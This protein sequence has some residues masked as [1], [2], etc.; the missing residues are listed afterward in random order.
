MTR[1]PRALIGLLLGLVPSSPTDA[2]TAFPSEPPEMAVIVGSARLPID[3]PDTR[4]VELAAKAP[5]NHA[6]WYEAWD[7][8]P[9]VGL[10]KKPNV[11]RLSPKADEEGVPILGGL[12]RAFLPETVEVT[13]PDGSRKFVAGT[14]YAYNADWGQIANLKGGLGEEFSAEVKVRARYGL[15][16]LDLVQAD[17]A[18]RASVKRGSSRPV[19]PALPEPDPGR[20]PLAGVYVGPR[21]SAITA[22]DIFPIQPKPPVAPI[23]A[24]AIAVTLGRLDR[25]EE[26][27]IAFLGDSITVG[28]EAGKWWEKAHA[29]TE[30]DLSW[31]GRLV[32]GLRQRFP[33]ATVTPIEGFSGGKTSAFGLE[34]LDRVVLPAV[35]SLV[36]IA[37]GTNDAGGKVG[38]EPTNPP[39][40]F[41][42][43]LLAMVKKARAAGAE[44]LLV[45]P[46]QVNPWLKNQQSERWSG[47]Q[48][49]ML[50]LAASETVGLADVH[51]EW[52]NL[53]SRGIPPFTQ[54]HNS[55]NHPGA[56]GHG[57][58]AEVLLRFFTPG[59]GAPAPVPSPAAVAPPT[60][61]AEPGVIRF[62]IPQPEK[63]PGN[64]ELPSQALPPLADITARP[65]DDRPV[66]GLYCWADEYLKHHDF[67]RD[68][69][70]KNFRLSGPVHDAV[71]KQYAEDGAEVMFTVSARRPM[72]SKDRTQ[73]DWRNR[74]DYP[75]DEA[76]IE[77]YLADVDRVL[78][79][80]AAH[81][82]FWKENP[83]L[84]RSPL[85]FLEIYNEPNFWY[86]DTAREDRINHF[87][88]K[89]PAARDAQNASRQKL[90]GKLLAAAYPRVKA[91]APEMSVVGF[92]A[93]GSS[94]ADVPFIKG[95]HAQLPAAAKCYD[96][97]STHPYVRPC[98][99]EG[100]DVRPYGR[101]SILGGWTQIRE[102]MRSTGSGD[103]PI[104]W[105]E[106]NWTIYPD[107]GGGY[108][109]AQLDPRAR[110]RDT[111]PELQAAY[112]VRG[113]ALAL[114]LGVPRLFYM[115]LVD[116]DNVNS[117]M[118][119]P[120]GTPRLSGKAV[121]AMIS[122]MPHPRIV[123]AVSDGDGGFHAWWFETDAKQTAGKRVLM[124]WN[125]AGP[126]TVSLPWPSS[127]V[128]IADMLG[129]EKA[130]PVS[131]GTL[132][133]RVGP[134]PL[135]LSAE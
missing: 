73:G 80:Y 113:Y 76:F 34:Q 2:A 124:A 33:K 100:L 6:R 107:S 118:L 55:V 20:T 75:T 69:G 103:K 92:G 117:G 23:N 44:V 46:M 102:I 37:F 43:E 15:Q 83:S 17:A 74:R 132:R 5:R 64:W 32:H 39:E 123:G 1:P 56:F 42:Q 24:G 127:R 84:P 30:K 61:E 36:I 128:R 4:S 109:L 119:S 134:C 86:L 10:D 48:K 96:I 65:P 115:S 88:P 11:I 78:D 112:L 70:W 114:R 79:R 27:R 21:A 45:T 130:F 129:E 126:K 87:P 16:R 72:P 93:G 35:P 62:G 66:Y 19:C 8:W 63:V 59:A 29:Y 22:A 60:P 108:S 110:D 125:V 90:Y 53:A 38:G 51:A 135:Y 31:R 47:Y 121:K 82:S 58:Y 52:L 18:G 101:F 85:R 67:I 105:T 99:P 25:G 98:P 14:H 26:A 95:V 71:M 116:T 120:A 54:L 3:P 7:P 122:L 77:D 91:R 133:L 111:T 131:G 28:A 9:D 104:W 97:L 40:Q 50:A 57:V 81:G 106:L 13:S 89:D 12:F 41:A 94:G 68:V 49:A